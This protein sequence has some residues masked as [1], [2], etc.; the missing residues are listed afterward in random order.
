MAAKARR[1]RNTKTPEGAEPP[2]VAVPLGGPLL[3]LDVSSIACGWVAFRPD[4]TAIDFGVIRPRA[5]LPSV[6]RTDSI[7]R[8][9]R[10]LHGHYLPALALME[11]SAGLTHGRIAKARG[12]A[13]LGQAQG[14]VK[15]ALV[16]L[17]CPV[18]TVAE[19][20][21]TNGVPKYKRA[22]RVAM[23]VP[24]YRDFRMGGKDRGDDAAD[25][26]GIGMW[27]FDRAREAELLA[28]ADTN[29]RV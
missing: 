26:L 22:N 17:H 15:Q 18:A 1:T 19:N 27:F 20:T 3:C 24:R 11:W 6:E 7:V 25:A 10:D 8:G 13:V 2:N 28:R 9:V 21:W 12:L 29:R 23:I 16:D 14:A 4:G 5:K